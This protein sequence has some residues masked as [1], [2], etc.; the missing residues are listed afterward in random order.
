L[1]IDAVDW[2]IRR[3]ELPVC[4]MSSAAFSNSE[5]LDCW[6][7]KEYLPK[8]VVKQIL[9]GVVVVIVISCL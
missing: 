9:K 5:G 4:K 7:S 6:P 1:I 2:M 3:E 8:I